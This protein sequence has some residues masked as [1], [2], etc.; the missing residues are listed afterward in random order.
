MIEDF[1]IRRT[2]D[3]DKNV[4]KN[5]INNKIILITGAGGSI[6]SECVRQCIRYK[7]SL[8][9]MVDNSEY[10]LYKI[11]QEVDKNI[12]IPI[13]K[14]VLD[15]DSIEETFKRYRPDIVIHTAAYK[16]VSLCELNITEAIKNNILGT[17]NIIDISCLHK[18]QKVIIT[19]TDKAVRPTSVMGVTK[20]ICEL[21]AQNISLEDEKMDTEVVSVRFGNVLGSSGSVI[22][23]FTSQIEQNKNITLTH[24]EVTRY[25]MLISEA[26]ELILQASSLG[27][28][29]EI[30]ILDMGKPIKIYDLAKKMIKLSGKKN[31]KIDIV[32]LQRGEKLCEELL[33]D[34]TDKNTKYKSITIAKPTFYDIK[35]L[36]EDIDELLSCDDKMSKLQEIVPEFYHR[37]NK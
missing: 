16:H 18:A 4:I 12:A 11:T 1:L 24:K 9:L 8:I 14:S 7:A 36:N 2:Q 6:G 26:C 33:L 22:P 23:K 3:L 19:S 17:K 20:R 35:K 15:K 10:N 32:G 31:I 30:F 21:Y 37:K 25:F 5:F 27:K 34:E 28:G 13:M 29:G